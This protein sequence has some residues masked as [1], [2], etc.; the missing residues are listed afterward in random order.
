LNFGDLET[1]RTQ[2]QE[3]LQSQDANFDNEAGKL[4]QA[5]LFSLGI[6]N[7]DDLFKQFSDQELEP[8]LSEKR[9]D[10]KKYFVF[11]LGKEL[12]TIPV[13][14]SDYEG[15]TF[16]EPVPNLRRVEPLLSEHL[17]QLFNDRQQKLAISFTGKNT[18]QPSQA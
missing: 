18:N 7:P 15:K 9:L 12:S 11:N 3:Y 13:T 5:I 1:L 2:Y 16:S 6:F 4:N 14:V 17:T 8:Y 10:L